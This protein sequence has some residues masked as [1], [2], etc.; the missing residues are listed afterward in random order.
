MAEPHEFRRRLLIEAGGELRLLGDVADD[1]QDRDFHALDSGWRC[2]AGQDI[3]SS[4]LRAYLE[5]PRGHDKTTG[6]AA[7][8]SWV[9]FASRRRIE[10]I[11][12]ASDREQ[13]QLIRDAAEKLIANNP[14]LGT[15]LQ[16]RNYEVR[17]QFTKSRLQILATDAAG[18]YGKMPDFLIVD[19]LTHW[20][21]ESN[22][23][24][25]EALFSAVAKRA[26]CMVVIISNAGIGEGSSWQWQIRE[27]A[28][29]EPSWYFS[30]IDGPKASWITPALLEEQRRML[31]SSAYKRLWLNLWVP[32][33]GDALE[34]ADVEAAMTL[35]GPLPGKLRYDDHVHIGGIDLGIKQDHTAVCV[36][37][38]KPA[39]G[40]IKLAE[41][42]SWK[43]PP[44]G[45][46]SVQTVED[47][48]LAM[49]CRYKVA[50]WYYDPH[51]MSSTAQ[52]LARRGIPIAEMKFTGQNLPMMASTILQVFRGR[53]IDL[54]P[55]PNLKRD[56]LRLCIV[57]K[58]YGYKL[59]AISDEYGHA[60]RAIAL[61]IALPMAIEIAEHPGIIR[62]PDGLG[63]N[64]MQA[65]GVP[66]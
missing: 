18:N 4:T 34:A 59:E 37:A 47:A 7:M 22:R 42:R 25:W 29:T 60:D 35:K 38:A 9:L 65:M 30:R 10:G 63:S 20:L 15:I 58:S 16:V 50:C 48:I 44:G 2:V 28:R 45:Q 41:I 23:L 43:P 62:R 32:G 56:L 31:P 8:A 26:H 11:A 21:Q 27:M 14:W 49:H 55:E 51:E 6:I 46:V 52:M 13:S 12:A 3:E 66:A 39:T 36:L 61:A 5:R 64:L 33:A 54:Y 17:N 1:W 53:K 24:N 57:E 19:E 40:R